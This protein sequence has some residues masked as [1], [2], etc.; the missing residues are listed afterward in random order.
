MCD[1]GGVSLRLGRNGDLDLG[2]AGG[3]FGQSLFDEGA[4]TSSSALYKV[5]EYCRRKDKMETYFMP[6]E[7]PAQ[8]Q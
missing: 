8:S 6:F 1:D 2:M 4:T 5:A 3:E 7:L